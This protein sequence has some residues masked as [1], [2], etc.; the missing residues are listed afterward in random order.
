MNRS[1]LVVPAVSVLA[2][3]GILAIAPSPSKAEEQPQSQPQSQPASGRPQ[4]SGGRPD[5]GRLL[6]EGLRA[7]EGCLGADA[8]QLQSGKLAII[9]WFKDVE[10]AKKWYY[11]ET[12]ARFMNAAGGDPEA[13]EPMRHITDPKT[14]VMVIAAITL[15]GEKVLPGPMPISQISIEMYTPLPGGAAVNGRLAPEGFN[16]PH[17]RNLD[18]QE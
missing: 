18:P 5:M 3:A 12:H 2:F 11:S 15:G 9:A 6:I 7:S 17:F 1:L 16:I 4:Q 13:R 10:A 8:A 14:P